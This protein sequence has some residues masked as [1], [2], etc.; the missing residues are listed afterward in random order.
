V[1]GRTCILFCL[2]A[3]LS[4]AHP[5]FA[6]DVKVCVGRQSLFRAIGET[7]SR[8]EYEVP[9][10]AGQQ[11]QQHGNDTL[12]V[13]W[14]FNRGVF[15]L[16][17]H[18]IT[19]AGCFGRGT[20]DVQVIGAEIKL[21]R[22]KF[23]LCSDSVEVSFNKADFQ[24]WNLVNK[25]DPPRKP[26][27][28]FIS[29]PGAY[30]LQAHDRDGCLISKQLSVI[31]PPKVNLG[32]DTM[33]C[34]P[35]FTLYALQHN[36]NP[37]GTVY[38]WSTGESGA[39]SRLDVSDRPPE[40]RVLYWVRAEFDGCAVSDTVVV[41]ACN[42]EDAEDL[43]LGIPNTFTPNGDGDNDVWQIRSLANYPNAVVEIFDRWGRRVMTSPSGYPEPWDGRDTEG[44]VLPLETYYYIIHLNDG[45]HIKPML[46]TITII[47]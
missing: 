6:Q 47:R 4:A 14:G 26:A 5:V 3:L 28:L 39:S 42:S 46:G 34:T 13:Q 2:T 21:E 44:R 16:E 25:S 38:T 37:E 29:R 33:I 1:S 17:V 27:G 41:L 31:A 32:K 22:E 12:L 9:P 11:R 19:L 35:G 7:G 36:T 15:K 40:E 45:V 18:E 23:V 8:F 24:A 10:E 20:L 30:E 43:P